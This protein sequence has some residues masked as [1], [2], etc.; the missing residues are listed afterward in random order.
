MLLV[1]HTLLVGMLRVDLIW[2]RKCR[3]T[4]TSLRSHFST[5]SL[6]FFTLIYVTIYCSGCIL[7]FILFLSDSKHYSNL[8][9]D[10]LFSILRGFLHYF[11]PIYPSICN[12]HLDLQ[13]PFHTFLH[14][15]VDF[16]GEGEGVRRGHIKPITPPT[17]GLWGRQ[18]LQRVTKFTIVKWF[19]AVGN[20][21]IFQECHQF[22]SQIAISP[23]KWI[24]K[25]ANGRYLQFA[26]GSGP[27]AI[28]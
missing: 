13:T 9:C 19:K 16:S 18:P 7:P 10:F 5:S 24:P 8:I 12:A 25:S 4:F 1:H 22:V 6:L 28:S 2:L 27:L 3:V 23:V 20:E 17:E 21:F 15:P 11:P 14:S 26:N